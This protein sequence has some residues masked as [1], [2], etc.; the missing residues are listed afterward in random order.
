MTSY[1]DAHALRTNLTNVF[2]LRAFVPRDRLDGVQLDLADMPGVRHVMA[3][4]GP[5][6][7]TLLV[8]AD[9][10]PA[11]AEHVLALLDGAG[12][13]RD[14]F[15]LSHVDVISVGGIQPTRGREM[16]WAEVLGNAR[17]SSRPLGTYLL[18]MAAAGVIAAFGEIERN[19]ILIVG[20]MAVSPDI[21]PLC[22]ACVGLQARRARLA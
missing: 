1:T 14:A 5:D 4:A 8:T 22:A 21:L 6:E 19:E 12:V 11:A 15:N 2:H 16:A 3:A 9:V 7:R 20:A 13:P 17:A 18:L 10:H